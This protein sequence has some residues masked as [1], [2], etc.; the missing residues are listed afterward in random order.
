MRG[1]GENTR[2]Y[3]PDDQPAQR[4]RKDMQAKK[5]WKRIVVEIL[6]VISFI[7]TGCGIDS[8]F[9]SKRDAITW[10]IAATVTIFCAAALGGDSE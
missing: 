5:V 10:A 2:H 8:I 7:L 6:F 1:A 4:G 3:R 9:V